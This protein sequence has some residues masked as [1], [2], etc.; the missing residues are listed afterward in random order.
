[1]IPSR[2]LASPDL[3]SFRRAE[4]LVEIRLTFTTEERVM[5][6]LYVVF[7]GGNGRATVKEY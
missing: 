2:N 4:L 5:Y 7:V 6:I 1:L 3:L